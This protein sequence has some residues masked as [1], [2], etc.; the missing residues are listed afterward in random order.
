MALAILSAFV[1]VLTRALLNIFDRQI[2]KKE[3][4]DFWK[5]LALNAI[6][7]FIVACLVAFIWGDQKLY[8]LKFI[9]EPGVIFSAIGA[10]LAAYAI[11]SSFRHM[12]VRSV[13]VSSKIADLFIPLMIFCVTNE[14]KVNN[15]IFSC[16]TTLIFIPI[17]VSLIRKKSY[18]SVF[19][20]LLLL[21]TLIF[22][23]TVNS[24]FRMHTFADTWAKFLSM[25]SCILLWRA[26]FMLLPLAFEYIRKQKHQLEESIKKEIN[27]TAL[28]F[29]A[30]LAFISQAAFFYSIAGIPTAVAWPILN[31]APFV[32]SFSAHIFLNERVEL[33]DAMIM[34]V[35]LIISIFYF[36]LSGSIV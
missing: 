33:L 12:T 21:T 23:A 19:S 4:T 3:N 22:Q 6:F 30:F 31:S 2:F 36:Y 16:L 20:S 1:C 11:S 15:Y 7:P 27:Y 26:V 14:F 8:F 29:R 5:S 17:L 28:F 32:T 18:F 24:Y 35:F 25:M 34:C 13:V 9:L 10:Q